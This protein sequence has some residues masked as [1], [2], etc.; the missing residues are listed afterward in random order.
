MAVTSAD[1]ATLALRGSDFFPS[2]D[3]RGRFLRGL[4]VH[5]ANGDIGA[6]RGK[7]EGDVPADALRGAGYQSNFTGKTHCC[8]LPLAT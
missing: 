3:I 8:S 5:V 1:A 6:V 7:R 2:F 4:E